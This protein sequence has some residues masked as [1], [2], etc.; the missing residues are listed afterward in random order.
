MG[1]SPKEAYKILQQAWANK[2]LGY[3][4][5]TEVYENLPND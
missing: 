4:D 2:I 5:N 3:V 1:A